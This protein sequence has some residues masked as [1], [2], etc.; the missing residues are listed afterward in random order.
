MNEREEKQTRG[1]DTAAPLFPVSTFEN[2][3]PARVRPRRLSDSRLFP[4]SF[5][6][7]D[8][9]RGC[10]GA[11]KLFLRPRCALFFLN[12]RPPPLPAN[13]PRNRCRP[14]VVSDG[15]RVFL[16]RYNTLLGNGLNLE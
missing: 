14:N 16:S 2:Y 15:T 9:R 8:A 12:V 6:Q 3:R 5:R 13:G 10:F 11:Q 7:S 1:E 4:P